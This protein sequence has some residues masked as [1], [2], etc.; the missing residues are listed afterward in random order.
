[1]PLSD[2]KVAMGG[3]LKRSDSMMSMHSTGSVLSSNSASAVKARTFLDKITEIKVVREALS[4]QVH[5]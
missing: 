2:L 5:R 1:M 4:R 3:T